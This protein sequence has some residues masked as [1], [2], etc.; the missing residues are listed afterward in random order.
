MLTNKD[1]EDLVQ[2]AEGYRVQDKFS[3]VALQIGNEKQK[4]DLARKI[5]RQW[6]IRTKLMKVKNS[7]EL[8]RWRNEVFQCEVRESISRTVIGN[9][10]YDSTPSASSNSGGR[11]KKRLSDNPCHKT[12]N[13]IL[14]PLITHLECAAA[15]E[16][17]TPH[18]L[19]EKLVQRAQQKW[20][21]PKEP[22][23]S[24]KRDI[25]VDA[26]CAIVYNVNFS[27]Q[28]F[29][30][31]RSYL[32]D[33]GINLPTRNEIDHY[34]RQLQCEFE[35]EA[36][37]TY[38]EFPVLVADTVKPL[39]DIQK[40]IISDGDIIHVEGKMGIDGSGSHQIRH[41]TAENE[42]S[43]EDIDDNE[44]QVSEKSYIGGFWCPLSISVN[45]HLVW[46]NIMPNSTLY[47]RPLCLLREKENRESVAEHF[48]P[49]IN[50][51]HQMEEVSNIRT[52]FCSFEKVSVHTELSM[53]DGKMVDLIQGDSGSY[54]HYCR[55]TRANANDLTCIIQG[56][57]IE[58]S[59]EEMSSTWDQIE[60]G[61]LA[62]ND[63]N[64]AGQ[65][66]KP[67]NKDDIRFFAI[68]HQKLRSLDNVL[69]LL[70]HLVSGQ[71]HTWSETNRYVKDAVAKGKRETIDHIRS[72]CGF[73]VDCPTQIGGNTNT[74][75]VAD[76]FFSIKNR[77]TICS[78]I[79]K[80]E[81][82]ANF[83]VL[84]SFF[85]KMLSITQQSDITKIVKP[86]KV[87]DLGQSLMLHYKRSFPWAMISPSVHQMCAHSWELF[88]MTEGKPISLYAEQSGEAWNKHI[89][90]YK[91]GPA[92]RARQCSIRL[93]TQDIFTR[94][95]LQSHPLIASRKKI[96]RCK[97][98]SKHG[99]TIR[100]CPMNFS[101]VLDAEKS[102]I[103]SCYI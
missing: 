2:Q 10:S 68:L 84:L 77:E 100:S 61:E 86:D 65:C 48:T 45:K 19:L 34:K 66:H 5:K 88:V 24:M 17:V 59:I 53:V 28:Q 21:Q 36:T 89:R 9:D 69:K 64:R 46:S 27:I 80:Q 76:R 67:L 103:D 20:G 52:S 22:Q 49:Y 6:E 72:K 71:T 38:C 18:F 33:F 58:K 23:E 101:T 4:Y 96:L 56:F 35:V 29:Q 31:L 62:Y 16:D 60:S 14:D 25:S 50:A 8:D 40:V 63:P 54:C 43:N 57:Q 79:L 92:A 82:R 55:V 42:C 97:R 41:Q 1:I 73:L 32:F 95:L 93:N 13:N 15:E 90:A 74:G 102:F 47:S 30:K 85:N 83:S 26:A 7:S 39:L 12:E 99:H 70:Y 98:C 11:P 75:P 44:R 91:S 81:D 3:N 51:A 94:M 37:K 87:K 78:L